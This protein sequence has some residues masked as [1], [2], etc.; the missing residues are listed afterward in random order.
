MEKLDDASRYA[1][2]CS[3]FGLEPGA[4]DVE[5][6]AAVLS[7]LEGAEFMP[8]AGW[9]QAIWLL[10]NSQSPQAWPTDGPDAFREAAEN[11]LAEVV[12]QFAAE[13]FSLPALPRRVKWTKLL[14]LANDFPRLQARLKGLQQGLEAESCPPDGQDKQD[15]ILVERVRRLFVLKPGDRAAQRRQWLAAMQ[16]DWRSAA[17]RIRTRYPRLAQLDGEFLSALLTSNHGAAMECSAAL[18]TKTNLAAA[19]TRTTTVSAA[20]SSGRP[21]SA[22]SS[23]GTSKSSP[24][25]YWMIY[26]AFML[27][28][29]LFRG[30][31]QNHEPYTTPNYPRIPSS[32][33]QR[34]NA[35]SNDDPDQQERLKRAGEVLGK[36]ERLRREAEAQNDPLLRMGPQPANPLP[37]SP[38][39]GGPL[40]PRTLPESP[41]PTIPGQSPVLPGI[42]RDPISP[43]PPSG[44]QPAPTISRGAPNGR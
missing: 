40:S 13:F 35:T 17:R 20:N 5:V 15:A 6:R 16:G 30:F 4:S 31:S 23:S 11:Q 7:Q 43:F 36:Q 28:S 3:V 37:A 39:P 29:A 41:L 9:R 2:A 22:L 21:A 24:G 14:K 10:A 12:D 38:L 1:W 25:A 44:S 26:V 42:L 32:P 27:I 34:W 33:P 19:I 18:T 8:P